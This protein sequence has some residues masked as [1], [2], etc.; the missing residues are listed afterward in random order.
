MFLKKK[1]K[2]VVSIL[3]LLKVDWSEKMKIREE[4]Y[5]LEGMYSG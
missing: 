1:T 4:K 3:I 2:T 5:I